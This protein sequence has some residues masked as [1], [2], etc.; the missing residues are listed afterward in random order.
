MALFQIDHE[1]G[2]LDCQ[3]REYVHKLAS[4]KRVEGERVIL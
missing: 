1:Q 2:Q 3:K 4:V